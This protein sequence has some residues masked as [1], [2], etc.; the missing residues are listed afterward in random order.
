MNFA[1][2]GNVPQG[3][4]LEHEQTASFSGITAD[5]L[6]GGEQAPMTVMAMS[7]APHQGAPAHIST[8]EDKIFQIT[9]GRLIFLVGDQRLHVSAGDTVFV[10]RGVVHSFSPLDDSRAQM[11]LVSTPAR[12]DRFFLAM[13]ELPLPHDPGDVQRVCSAFEQVIVGPVVSP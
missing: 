13:N 3:G 12:H 6:L 4:K 2:Q 7:I 8:S 5:I 9:D 1:S 10:P 11:Q